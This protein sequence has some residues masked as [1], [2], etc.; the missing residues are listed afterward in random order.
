M[1][2]S[3]VRFL[4]FIREREGIFYIPRYQR[5]YDWSDEQCDV[6]FDDIEKVM[7]HNEEDVTHFMGIVVYAAF[8]NGT[9]KITVVDGQQ[10]LITIMLLL[11]AIY[12]T[13]D[14]TELKRKIMDSYLT[15]TL[16]G[17]ETASNK[18]KVSNHDNPF[19]DCIINGRDFHDRFQIETLEDPSLIEGLLASSHV[20]KN[21]E[22]LKRRVK[23]STLLPRQIFDGIRRLEVVYVELN[24]PHENPQIIFE[25]L[26]SK[27]LD[28]EDADLIKN[29]FFMGLDPDVQE[30][31]YVKYWDELERILPNEVTVFIKDYLIMKNCKVI[32]R[33]ANGHEVYKVF[34]DSFPNLSPEEKET[35]LK[36][37]IKYANYYAWFYDPHSPNE[38]IN[39][40]LKDLMDLKCMGA[41]P[42][43]LY[44]FGEYYSEEK[45]DQDELCKS[46]DVIES[47]AMRRMLCNLGPVTYSVFSAMSLRIMRN[48]P[49]LSN[50]IAVDL[51]YRIGRNAFP[52]DEIV[53]TSILYYRE[54]GRFPYIDKILKRLERLNGNQ[55]IP[56]NMY[57]DYIMPRVYD[58][59]IRVALGRDDPVAH[60]RLCQMIGNL[61]PMHDKPINGFS[62]ADFNIKCN[63]YRESEY[64]ITR[65]IAEHEQWGEK[66]IVQRSEE[67]I[68]GILRIWSYPE[69][70]RLQPP[71]HA[72][73]RFSSYV[74]V[75]DTTPHHLSISNNGFNVASWDELYVT[76]CKR[77]CRRDPDIFRRLC[78]SFDFM[79]LNGN[80]YISDNPKKLAGRRK[81][82][83]GNNIF[84]STGMSA[85]DFLHLCRL[86]VG[87]YS[88]DDQITYTLE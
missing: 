22:L 78:N 40:R 14:D 2:T 88:L 56:L 34:K 70:N 29:F 45:E 20:H 47:Y 76:L 50:Q 64:A 6:L 27:G 7:Q 66:E 82:R 41:Y 54:I 44:I 65:E 85:N 30:S 1:K 32:K 86:I 25:S 71:I 37:L 55:D 68:E 83:I 35:L 87:A 5:D 53:K 38:E 69:V 8:G 84:V 10:R 24:L 77:M 63:T 15:Y 74:D 26:N 12:D 75:T 72:T 9:S 18:L 61:T 39:A 48:L 46:L 57:I 3:N 23:K 67:M 59:R 60:S 21:Y 81:E 80:Y 49:P 79:T 36:E 62:E 73:N 16:P 51:Y 28:L 52:E 58:D 42:F 31:L 33:T 13:T 11:R 19:F 17:D 43:L 4:D